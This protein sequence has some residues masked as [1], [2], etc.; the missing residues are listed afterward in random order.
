MSKG[1]KTFLNK[2]WTTFDILNTVIMILF[3]FLTLYPLYYVLIGSFNEGLDYLSGGVY[4]WPRKFVFDNYLIILTDS[5]LWNSYLITFART[6]LGTGTAILFTSIVAYA[7][8]RREL[9][10]RKVFYGLNIF[11]MFFGGGLIPFFLVINLLG[12]F[13]NFLIYIIPCMYSVYNMIIMQSF[14]KSIPDGLHEA[15]VVDGAD[16]FCIFWKIYM[17]LSKP[18]L[19]TVSLWIAVGHWNSFF[20]SM[21]FTSNDKLNTLQH[22]LYKIINQANISTDGIQLPVEILERISPQTVTYAAI[23]VS[24]LPVLCIYPLLQKY[25]EKGLTIGSLKG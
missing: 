19:A 25:F 15:A 14:F 20:D 22:F 8:S 16:E 9:R 24:T 2:K 12:L 17:P 4:F 1:K 10:Y 23:L 13:N 7:M 11:T 5:R 18:V 6:I 21:V 3:S